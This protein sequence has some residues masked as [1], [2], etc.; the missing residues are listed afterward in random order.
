[1]NTVAYTKELLAAFAGCGAD[2]AKADVVLFA[3]AMHIAHSLEAVAGS[4]INIGAQ[5]VSKT[6]EGAF[7]GIAPLG[8]RQGWGRG[9]AQL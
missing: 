7:T 2:A 1:M 9:A 4:A 3:P 5:N 6:G 8:D